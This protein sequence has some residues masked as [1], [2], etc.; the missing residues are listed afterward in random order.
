MSPRVTSPLHLPV[1]WLSV[2]PWRRPSSFF[3]I[4]TP[5][6]HHTP[7]RLHG[8]T[9]LLDYAQIDTSQTC[10]QSCSSATYSSM[11]GWFYGGWHRSDIDLHS[12]INTH[13]VKHLLTMQHSTCEW[14]TQC[15]IQHVELYQPEE[16]HHR[17]FIC[18]CAWIMT[19]SWSGLF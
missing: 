1:K 6:A 12:Q 8:H 3:L 2:A 9:P 5:S 13:E 7:L 15:H 16:E 4:L 10:T 17:T 18:R 19:F 11:H 14:H